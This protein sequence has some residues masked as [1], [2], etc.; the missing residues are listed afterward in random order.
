MINKSVCLKRELFDLYYSRL[1]DMQRKCIYAVDGPTLILAGAGSGKTTVLVN[2]IVHII[3]Y[4]DAYNSEFIPD[5]VSDSDME[6]AKSL[7]HDELGLF[8]DKFAYNTPRPWEVMAITFTNK[9]AKEIKTRLSDAFGEGSEQAYDIWAG[10]FHSICMRLIRRYGD[11]MGYSRDAGICD[12]DDAK[13][14]I[15]D[16]MKKLNIDTKQ[17]PVKSV[18]S[19][20]S[21]AKDQLMSASDFSA[22]AG[23]DFKLKQIARIYEM[24]SARLL[25]ANIL[26]FDDIIM[27]T[28]FM[29]K[30]N[31]EI[32]TKL[33]NQFKYVLVDEFQDTNLAQLE[34]TTLLSGGYDNIMV[35]GDD[36]QSIYK[37]RGATI[38][39]ILSFDKRYKDVRVIRL[40]QNYRSTKNILDAANYVI[41]NNE[42]RH[43]KNLWCDGGSG[44][45]ISLVKLQ[46]QLDEAKYICDTITEKVSGG[47]ASY[48]DFAVLYRMNSQSRSVEQAMAKAGIPYRLLA[49]TRFFDRQEIRDIVAYL[50]VINNPSDN[51][52]LRRIANVPKRGI[53]DSSL[54]KADMLASSLGI[55]LLELMKDA[56]SHSALPTAAAHAMEEFARMMGEFRV[57]AEEGSVSE[58]IRR[59][60]EISGYENM[61]KAAGESEAERLENIGELVSM[62]AQYEQNADE[63]SLSEFLIDVALVSDV[64]K[65]DESADAVVLMTI[66]SA[67]G[68]EFPTVFL[69]G[70]E[71]GIFP[72]VQ[73][74]FDPEEVEEERRLC[75]VAITRAKRKLFILHVHERMLNGSTQ[76]NKISRFAEEIPPELVE[77]ESKCS[78]KIFS[79]GNEKEMH[80]LRLRQNG[81]FTNSVSATKRKAEQNLSPI[82]KTAAA[83]AES[84]SAGARVRHV[85]FGAGTVVSAKPMGGDI[86]YEIDFEKV[87]VKKLMATYARLSKA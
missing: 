48:R 41:K 82:K 78:G 11:A 6:A 2:R 86:M 49:G 71:E 40:E 64:D 7:S 30:Y 35:V 68:L 51:I 37:F 57:M 9:A 24:Y 84:F 62:A 45:P 81:A 5:G 18:M 36:D 19:T 32:R 77:E 58:L 33:Q 14:L 13:K 20:I 22:E 70:L 52:H 79:F 76:Y 15:T 87:G 23:N 55:S 54:S 25:E 4:G 28:V 26:D 17:L 39:N 73:S 74:F 75:Y 21:R 29:L 72:G 38:E 65:Y 69:P 56:S 16:C 8:L 10:T 47:S 34:L 66:H 31:A 53:G 85:T 43:A 63:P 50:C 46:T 67:K 27:Q 3:R 1:N 12:T 83:P 60:S 80:S 44:D 42:G 61:L 59:V